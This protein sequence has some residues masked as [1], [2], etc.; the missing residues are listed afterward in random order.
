M[1]INLFF[2]SP[3]FILKEYVQFLPFSITIASFFLM[4]LVEPADC[5]A[6]EVLNNAIALEQ[7]KAQTIE[8]GGEVVDKE[9]AHQV[10]EL[11]ELSS[12]HNVKLF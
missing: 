1:N 11:Y 12:K 9:I 2:Y 4:E 7:L 5:S 10:M 6:E 8:R 3:E